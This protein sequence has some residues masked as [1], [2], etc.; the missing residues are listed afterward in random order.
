[1]EK[2]NP[3]MTEAA[4][5]EPG[6]SGVCSQTGLSSLKRVGA[7]ESK[8]CA[9]FSASIPRKPSAAQII[10]IICSVRIAGVFFPKIGDSGGWRLRDHQ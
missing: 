4:A 5:S 6:W 2:I 3:G 10:L 9:R 7:W 1:M 8:N